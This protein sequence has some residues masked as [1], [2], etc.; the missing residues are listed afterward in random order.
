[1][2]L[3]FVIPCYNS[4][5]SIEDIVDRIARTM[6]TR[7]HYTYEIICVNDCSKD[8]TYIVLKELAG[9]KKIKA[10]DLSRNFGQHGALMAGFHYVT[11]DIIVCLDDDGQNAPEEMFKLIDKLGE[12]YDL[13][14]AKYEKDKRSLV[15]R[16]GSRISFM[17]SQKLIGM[18]KDIELNSY[19]VFRRY[20]LDEV[21]K[22]DNPY[23]FV[24]GLMLRVTRNIANVPIER[25]NRES[26]QSGYSL[27]K[28][29]GLWMN[30]FIGFSELPLRMVSV[31]GIFF[32]ILGFVAGVFVVIRRLMNPNMPMGYSSILAVLLFL[33]GLI[34]LFMGLL[35]EYVGRIYISLNNAPQ[36]VVR[37]ELNVD[38]DTSR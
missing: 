19:Y 38:K 23:P 35:G 37:E 8:G 22:Y 32:S 3:S 31:C 14:S 30:G 17:M 2:K 18:P 15:R 28:L 6:E 29:L 10:I 24:H 9:L 20:V 1:M 5:K 36:F 11:G 34:M 21:L 27:K 26:G 33:F 4:E 16:I 25:H 7:P 13:V 12:G